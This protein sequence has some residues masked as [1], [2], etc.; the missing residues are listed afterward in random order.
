MAKIDFDW[1]KIDKPAVIR[2]RFAVVLRSK[3]FD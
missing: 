3:Q 1:R 2:N